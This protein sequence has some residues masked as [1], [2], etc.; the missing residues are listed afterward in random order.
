MVNGTHLTEASPALPSADSLGGFI[1]TIA[2][3]VL[4]YGGYQAILAFRKDHR[5]HR[6]T[7]AIDVADRVVAFSGAQ[8]ERL[9]AQ[10]DSLAKKLE[11]LEFKT[12]RLEERV[13]ALE[14]SN[15]DLAS[16]ITAYRTRVQQLR[17]HITALVEYITTRHPG[18]DDYP[19]L[20]EDNTIEEG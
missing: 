4:V 19:K 8:L 3:V 18:S 10:N 17:D 14:R 15:R 11:S 20:L 9:I 7:D 6:R 13:A 2:M 12:D 16:Q 5:K 1:I